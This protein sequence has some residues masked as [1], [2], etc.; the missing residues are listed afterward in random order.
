MMANMI[1]HTFIMKQVIQCPGDSQAYGKAGREANIQAK[2][3]RHRMANTPAERQDTERA[4]MGICKDCYGDDSGQDIL[5]E[6]HNILQE[7][8]NI[9]KEA[10]YE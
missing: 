8:H 5:Q 1:T 9:L 2:E 7:A 3:Q 4:S 10:P 6:T